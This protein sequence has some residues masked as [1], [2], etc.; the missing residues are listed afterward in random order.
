MAFMQ[1][2]LQLDDGLFRVWL[3]QTSI[4]VDA[5]EALA[6]HW[7]RVEVEF[8]EEEVK[9]TVDGIYEVVSGTHAALD[10]TLSLSFLDL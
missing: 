5:P 10:R 2:N 8:R 7:M 3:G 9:T 4:L 1:N 6:S